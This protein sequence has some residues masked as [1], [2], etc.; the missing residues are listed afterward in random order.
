MLHT[1]FL[2]RV[3][4]AF[5]CLVCLDGLWL[6]ISFDRIYKPQFMAIQKKIVVRTWSAILVWLLLASLI[7]MER[8]AS[9]ATACLRGLLLGYIVYG[10]YNFTNYT[11]LYKYSLKVAVVDTIWGGF[12]LAITSFVLSSVHI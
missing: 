6:W 10:T 9:P 12:A 4:I 3:F 5:L 8:P 1:R 2:Y 11:T 7:A